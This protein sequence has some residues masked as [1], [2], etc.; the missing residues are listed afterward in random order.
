MLPF[1]H[2]RALRLRLPFLFLLRWLSCLDRRLERFFAS[3]YGQFS[4]VNF[5]SRGSLVHARVRRMIICSSG[6]ARVVAGK[7]SGSPLWS[8]DLSCCTARRPSGSVDR[9][10]SVLGRDGSRKPTVQVCGAR[11]V[12]N[13]PDCWCGAQSPRTTI[14]SARTVACSYVQHRVAHF[15][16]QRTL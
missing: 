2:G 9:R 4:L 14:T 12:G 13:G 10:S 6:C 5:A 8:E 15:S 3:L 7:Q 11:Q 1:A 16:V